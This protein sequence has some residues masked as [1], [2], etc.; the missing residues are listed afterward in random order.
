MRTLDDPNPDGFTGTIS[1]ESNPVGVMCSAEVSGPITGCV[2]YGRG[3][4]TALGT[5][6]VTATAT[7]EF[8][9]SS[10]SEPLS[11]E[12]TNATPQVILTS[13]ADGSLVFTDQQVTFRATVIDEDLEPYGNCAILPVT[14][15]CVGWESSVDGPLIPAAESVFNFST[16]L[17][18]GMHTITVTATDGQGASNA[19]SIA[20]E[21]LVGTGNPTARI[22]SV[23]PSSS[24]GTGQIIIISG[25]GSDPED[26]DLSEGSLQWFSDR[27]GNIGSGSPLVT[28][29][30]S[31]PVGEG[32]FFHTIT[33]VVTDD[34]NNS[35]TDQIIVMV[36]Q[37]D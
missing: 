29:E 35:A 7:D 2:T 9:A 3:D 1:V 24:V 34:D 5:H 26:G 4:I 17:S 28:D 20:V 14:G 32:I 21:V 16:S 30:L 31:G 6:I 11:I 8:G 23:L 22:T 37:I 12:I 25:E 13:P 10:V 19:A 15:A 18:A 36:G 27:D 33:L